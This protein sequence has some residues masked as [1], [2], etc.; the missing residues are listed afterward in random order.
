L[1]TIFCLAFRGRQ[2]VRGIRQKI[3]LHHQVT[4][5]G[6]KLVNVSGAHLF[7]RTT[8]AREGR[9][10]ILIAARFQVP[11]W[12]E[13]TPY[14]LDNTARVISSRI[15]SSA[16]LAL[17]S[18]EWFFR[19]FILDHFFLRAIHFNNWSEI[20]RPPLSVFDRSIRSNVRIDALSSLVPVRNTFFNPLNVNLFC[21]FEIRT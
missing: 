5:L 7:R 11:I 4:N 1:L 14:F 16:T 21:H 10:H 20:P 2:A 8:A 12:V 15:A 9:C 13:W 17:N 18:G 19:F 6:V 3:P